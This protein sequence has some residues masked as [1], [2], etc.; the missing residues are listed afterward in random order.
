MSLPP[1][2]KKE[3]STSNERNSAYVQTFLEDIIRD[4]IGGMVVMVDGSVVGIQEILPLNFYQKPIESQDEIVENFSSLFRAAP[5]FLHLKMY[6]AKADVNKLIAYINEVNKDEV[7]KKVLDEIPA[8]IEYIRNLQMSDSV[9]RRYFIIWEYEG[10][11]NG[12]MSTDINEIYRSMYETRIYIKNRIHETGNLSVDP[13]T[14]EDNNW[15]TCEL[16]YDLFNPKSSIIEPFI[17]RVD[18]LTMDQEYFNQSRRTDKSYSVMDFIAARGMKIKSTYIMAD[19][20]YYTFLVL[21][22]KGHPSVAYGGWTNLLSKGIGYDVDILIKKL[23]H[24]LVLNVLN[25][26]NRYTGAYASLNIN[27][28]DKYKDIIGKLQNKT[29][30]QDMLKQAGEDLWNVMIIITIRS[31]TY[32]NMLHKKNQLIKQLEKDALYTDDCFLT[33]LDYYKMTMP[34]NIVNNRLFLKNARNYLTSSLGSLYNMTGNELFDDK[35]FVVG[36]G[37]RGALVS[38]NPF[39]TSLYSN[40]NIAIFGK[41]GT[42]KTFMQCMFAY[43][44][45]LSGRRVF[46]V[47]PVKG[48]EY[49]GMVNSVGGTIARLFPGSTDCVNI[50][51]IRPV[52]RINAEYLS[53]NDIEGYK[54]VSL[55]A[56]K[57]TFLETFIAACLG[58]TNLDKGT[59]ARLN[60]IIT[61]IYDR[62]GITEDNDSIYRDK[63]KTI[64]KPMPI[65]EDLYDAITRYDDLQYIADALLPFVDGTFSNFNGQTNIDLSNKCIAFDI[66]ARYVG[67]DFL[68]PVMLTATDFCNDMIMQDDISQDFLMVDEMWRAMINDACAKK[69]Q[70]IV[71]LIRGYGGSLV[72]ATQEIDDCI[73]AITKY[74]KS[75]L[76]NTS[77]KIV[78]RV[79]KP[80]LKILSDYVDLSEAD[81]KILTH[82]TPKKEGMILSE[83]EQIKLS[84]I[85]SDKEIETFTTDM[86]TKKEIQKAKKKRPKIQNK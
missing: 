29:Y 34:F 11:N 56:K 28:T 43:R 53:S 23:P 70:E 80:Q 60:S 86:N 1:L 44:A 9:H 55:L 63:N 66:D 64:L 36:A 67:E 5:N 76:S 78:L 16:L 20:Q 4:V 13:L 27:K 68:P 59:L 75:I 45:R 82:L 71:K 22:D 2:S 81:R 6:T 57:I 38:F 33:A 30:I 24:D 35:G 37:D 14:N 32:K 40:A 77:I 62:F 48:H 10:D 61:E 79:D 19:G 31:N 18:R 50:M 54:E 46:L 21:K 74:G 52:L 49:Y 65:I 17:K 39:N 42:G 51:Q 85:A 83:A 69:I 58:N 73:D 25:Y 12:K 72:V 3:K 41:S 26:G 47:L 15:F 7:N 8:Y 84:F